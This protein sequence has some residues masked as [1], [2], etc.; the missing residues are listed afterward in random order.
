MNVKE[1]LLKIILEVNEKSKYEVEL[2]E[3]QSL[4]ND[5][6]FDS[7]NIFDLVIKIEDEF[8]IEIEDEY[9]DIDI[10]DNVNKLIQIIENILSVKEN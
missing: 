7:I 10:I 5:F 3:G 2:K 4:I 8:D 6:N 9:L 1:R